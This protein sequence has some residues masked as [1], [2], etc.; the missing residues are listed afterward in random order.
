MAG[1][2]AA[3]RS[4]V[5]DE[6][7]APGFLWSV[8]SWK[9]GQ[10]LGK[11]VAMDQV[12]AFGGCYGG[13]RSAPGLF[14][15]DGDLTSSRLTRN[16]QLPGLVTADWGSVFYFAQSCHRLFVSSVFQ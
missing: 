5:I 2:L 14:A 11:Q 15:G 8:L 13:G 6:R 9:R 16:G 7:S 3:G 10:K 1:P 4:R 12:L